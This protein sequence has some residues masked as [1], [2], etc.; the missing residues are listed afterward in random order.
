M[1]TVNDEESTDDSKGDEDEV[2]ALHNTLHVSR[3]IV[4]WSCSS[5]DTA[6]HLL[7]RA[8]DNQVEFQFL[9]IE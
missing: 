8:A 3:I 7:R 1:T 2:A 9:V 6:C 5:T 4:H